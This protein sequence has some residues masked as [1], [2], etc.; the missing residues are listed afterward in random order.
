M[1]IFQIKHLKT[2]WKLL[3]KYLVSVNTKKKN[4]TQILFTHRLFPTFKLTL[5]PGKKSQTD[6]I[7]PSLQKYLLED[8]YSPI[9]KKYSAGGHL[10]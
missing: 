3:S 6:A 2:Y 9:D 10:L 4:Q 1:N 7:I 5:A 8:N